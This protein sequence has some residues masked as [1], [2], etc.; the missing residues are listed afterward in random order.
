MIFTIV[1]NVVSSFISWLAGFLTAHLAPATA[2]AGLA[3]AQITVSNYLAAMDFW[4]PVTV[5]TGFLIGVYIPIELAIWKFKGL[6][7]GYKKIPGID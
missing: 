2:A 1:I 3:A 4:F 7:W 5:V 6:R